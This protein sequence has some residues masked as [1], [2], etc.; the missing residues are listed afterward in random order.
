[1]ATKM[2]FGTRGPSGKNEVDLIDVAALI[3]LP[4]FASMIFGVFTFQ[5][6]IFT[7]YD[8]TSAIWTIGGAAISVALLGAVFSMVWVLGTN[9]LND[10]TSHEGYELAVI[11]VAIALPILVVFVPAIESLVTMNDLTRLMAWI[12]VSVATVWTSF[13]A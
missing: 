8:M 11:A 12:Y 5:I 3:A 4:V 1:M 7:S 10:K 13:T 9:V 6:N 2:K